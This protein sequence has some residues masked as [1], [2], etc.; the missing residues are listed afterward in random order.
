MKKFFDAVGNFFEEGF[1]MFNDF[2]RDNHSNPILWVGIIIIGLSIAM[3][4]FNYL[5]KDS[6]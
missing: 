3:W 4:A 5:S 1:T 2:I 6:M